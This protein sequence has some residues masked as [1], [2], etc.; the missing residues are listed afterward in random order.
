MNG[1]ASMLIAIASG[2]GGTGKTT[3]AVNLAVVLAQMGREVAYVDGDVEAP[4]GHLFFK[5]RIDARFPVNLPVPE[6]DKGACNSCGKCAEICQYGAIIM[7]GKQVLIFPDLC[8]GCGGCRLVCPEGAIQEN[9]HPIGVVEEGEAGSVSFIQGCLDIGHPLAP[10]V[11][12]AAR[13]RLPERGIRLIDAPPGTACAAVQA[14]E[15]TDYVLLVA[16]PTPFGLNDLQL[17]VDMLRSLQLPFGLV[18]NRVDD[19]SEDMRQYC[20]AE[21]IDILL[22]LPDDRRVAEAY[23]RGELMVEALPEY[24]AAFVE[25][26]N[27][28]ERRAA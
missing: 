22:E 3:I 28:L 8:H 1:S 9:P 19:G 23:S 4:N 15:G 21:Q 18:I 5:P 24:R 7:L 25:L 26:G 20:A 27:R 6:L 16:E 14:V 12:R 10:P 2:K 13:Q 17:S 11:I